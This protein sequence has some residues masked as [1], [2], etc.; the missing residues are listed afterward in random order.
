M[1]SRSSVVPLISS[2]QASLVIPSSIAQRVAAGQGGAEGTPARN[3]CNTLLAHCTGTVMP[4][5]CMQVISRGDLDTL[6][7][8]TASNSSSSTQSPSGTP[9]SAPLSSMS[10]ARLTA[11]HTGALIQQSSNSNGARLQL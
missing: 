8:G 6:D 4:F 10:G 5:L 11:Q 3:P 2:H 9:L 1:K 7:Q